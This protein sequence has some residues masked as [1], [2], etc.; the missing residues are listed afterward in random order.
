MS[1]ELFLSEN[2]ADIWL[3]DEIKVHCT[4]FNRDHYQDCF[5]EHLGVEFPDQMNKSVI[6][7][8][9]EYLAGRYCALNALSEIGIKNYQIQTGEHRA[10]IWPDGI[11]GSISHNDN[12]AIAAISKRHNLCG[13]GVDVE[14]VMSTVTV[15]NVMSQILNKEE[16]LLISTLDPENIEKWFTA[17]FSA[18]ESFFKAAYSEVKS[19][20]GF[21]AVTIK[22]V[23][24]E[25]STLQ[26]KLNTFLSTSL[27]EYEHFQVSF[28]HIGANKILTFI[29]I[30]SLR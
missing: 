4:R 27:E 7:R 6:K 16:E 5:Y 3:G 24:I 11:L 20:F 28:R 15:N 2:C 8:R 1:V 30:P 13:I 23:D 12:F 9:A 19:Y 25:K 26:L 17:F 21:D 18:K 14:E 22:H 10:P 29:K